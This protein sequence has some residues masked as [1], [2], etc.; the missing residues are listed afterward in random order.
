MVIESETRDGSNK[1]K[2]RKA[3]GIITWESYAHALAESIASGTAINIEEAVSKESHI[4]HV[5]VTDQLSEHYYKSNGFLILTDKEE[6]IVGAV[7][8]VEIGNYLTS[9]KLLLVFMRQKLLSLLLRLICLLVRILQRRILVV[10]HG[11]HQQ[12]S[13]QLV[14]LLHSF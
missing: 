11:V 1:T 13:Q 8:R 5:P 2:F 4:T 9:N 6:N 7:S 14:L 10:L 3:R 12:I